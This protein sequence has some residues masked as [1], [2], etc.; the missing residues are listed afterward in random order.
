MNFNFWEILPINFCL[1]LEKMHHLLQ[2]SYD[3]FEKFMVQE[4]ENCFL[5]DKWQKKM[6]YLFMTF[7][8][9]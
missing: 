9:N 4:Q 3:L 8:L 5:F 1:I 6:E 2:G 7:D